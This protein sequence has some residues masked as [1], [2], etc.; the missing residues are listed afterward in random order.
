[1]K[2]HAIRPSEESVFRRAEAA[3]EDISREVESTETTTTAAR[4]KGTTGSDA[5]TRSAETSGIPLPLPD[6][7][8]PDLDPREAAF[9]EVLAGEREEELEDTEE[10]LDVIAEAQTGQPPGTT[11]AVPVR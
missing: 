7:A 4:T 5:T 8:P 1:A 10:G 6:D 11:D 9:E 2:I 3:I